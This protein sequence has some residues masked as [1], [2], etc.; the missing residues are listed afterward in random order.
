MYI[1]LCRHR[2]Y[3]HHFPLPEMITGTNNGNGVPE[4]DGGGNCSRFIPR[5][6]WKP[7]EDAKLKELVALHGAHN[8]NFIAHNL[9]GRSGKS[10]RLRW[11][12][13]LD[14]KLNRSTFTAEEE[15]RLVEAQKMY[16]NKWATIA[17]LYF[18][19]RTDNAV[20]NHWHVL[21]ARNERWWRQQQIGPVS[22]AS[23][24]STCGGYKRMKLTNVINN[25]STSS[26]NAAAATESTVDSKST[27][28]HLSLS[29]ASFG[30]NPM[31]PD[32]QTPGA[33]TGSLSSSGVEEGKDRQCNSPRP[34]LSTPITDI[35]LSI[36]GSSSSRTEEGKGRQCY[37][38][39]PI[40]TTPFATKIGLSITTKGSSSSS[41]VRRGGQ[42]ESS[43]S[44][45]SGASESVANLKSTNQTTDQSNQ[46]KK[47]A[48]YDFL[49]MGAT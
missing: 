49:G 14:P 33:V 17:R 5:G 12:N 20:K 29:A 25:P 3:Y 8:W 26:F 38:P 40:L 4:I 30:R 48:F 37:S 39:L 45:V 16:G 1:N 21:L 32:F 43:N 23:F 36:T 41:K 22:A 6:H 15:E 11:Y 42:S 28:S 35:G 31:P 34:I 2:R 46:L 7:D 18:P 13:Q 9:P 44:E 47:I 27:C 24:T 19:C 10:C